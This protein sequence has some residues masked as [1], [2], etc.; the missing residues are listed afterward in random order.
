MKVHNFTGVARTILEPPPDI[1]LEIGF[2]QK[3]N[4]IIIGLVF[5]LISMTIFFS[6]FFL[7]PISISDFLLCL[8]ILHRVASRPINY[9]QQSNKDATLARFLQELKIGMILNAWKFVCAQCA[10]HIIRDEMI[11]DYLVL[12]LRLQLIIY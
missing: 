12:S 7:Q 10:S 2:G 6:R 3:N 1:E 9:H 11:I 5:L 8:I 4:K